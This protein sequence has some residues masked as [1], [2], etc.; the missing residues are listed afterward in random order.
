MAHQKNANRIYL[1]TI[2]FIIA[3]IIGISFSNAKD[4]FIPIFNIHDNLL[5]ALGLSLAYFIV[6]SGWI[7]FHRS[8]SRRP[9]FGIFGTIR[10]CIDL[11][12]LFLVYYLIEIASPVSEAAYG[13]TF[14]W[15]IPI[16]F[17]CYF[18]WDIVKYHEYKN[19]GELVVIK[20]DVSITLVFAILFIVLSYV[21]HLLL[22]Y[23]FNYFTENIHNN[24]IPMDLYFIII[25][26]GFVLFYRILKRRVAQ[27]F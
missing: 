10:Y 22:F 1:I 9:H 11:V 15:V 5:D 21:Y 7:G 13:E 27:N 16:M 2:E 19:Q 24:K 25:S 26:F 23:D 12:I 3:V 14:R 20:N 18:L 8:I 4:V 6:I 17:F